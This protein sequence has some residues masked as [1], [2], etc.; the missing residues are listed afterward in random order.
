MLETRLRGL[1]ERYKRL[2]DAAFD[3]FAYDVA[4]TYMIA[5]RGI[6]DALR[7][8]EVADDP[9]DWSDALGGGR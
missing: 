1:I 7:A 3:S 8:A 2:S 9:A 6:G 4:T 5:Y